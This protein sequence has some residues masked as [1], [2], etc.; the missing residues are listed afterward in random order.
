MGVGR[1]TAVHA[2]LL[3]VLL[4]VLVHAGT[5]CVGNGDFRTAKF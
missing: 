3:L 2:G 5:P 1:P 4:L